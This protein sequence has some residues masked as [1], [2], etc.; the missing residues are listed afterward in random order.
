MDLLGDGLLQ[1]GLVLCDDVAHAR[2]VNVLE[3]KL[4]GRALARNTSSGDVR[5]FCLGGEALVGNHPVESAVH[6][7]TVATL[8]SVSW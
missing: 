2:N 8:I 4:L 6:V 5:V 3:V 7:A 1:V